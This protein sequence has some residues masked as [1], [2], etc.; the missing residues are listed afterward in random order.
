MRIVATNTPEEQVKCRNC[1][2]LIA[3][4]PAEEKFETLPPCFEE[5]R[6]YYVKCPVC[7]KKIVT[8]RE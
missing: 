1:S 2:S 4:F 5:V 3:Y 7:G 8:R 6:E